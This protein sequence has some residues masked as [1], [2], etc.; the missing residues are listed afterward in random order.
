VL[1]LLVALSIGLI[2]VSY[3]PATADLVKGPQMALLDAVAP[4]ERGL[5]RA[6]QPFQSAY[7]WT[8]T[9]LRSTE[10]NPRLHKRVARSEAKLAELQR[11]RAE[12][13]RL[14]AIL[15]LDSKNTYPTG[16]D[17]VVGRVIARTPNAIDRAIVV[18]VGTSDGVQVDDPVMTSAGLI[19]IVRAV[20]GNS[21]QVGLIINR[22][23]AVTATVT[24]SGATGVMRSASNE[25]SPVLALDYVSRRVPVRVGDRVLTAGWR[26][27]SLQSLFPPGIPIGIVSG[28][29]NSPADLFKSVQVTPNA[30]FDRLHEVIVLTPQQRT[31]PPPIEFNDNA[32][33]TKGAS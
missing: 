30:D 25:G 24:G 21:A 18:D 5:D 32:A 33:R 8:R 28:V 14:R 19:G 2:T 4:I 29:G 17:R 20:S 13:V 12:N 11:L 26:S 7:D 1:G 9:L 6:W 31:A 23:Q 16:Y 3:H 10:E 15:E 27:G 22:S